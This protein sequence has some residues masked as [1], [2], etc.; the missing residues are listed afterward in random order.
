MMGTRLPILS[1]ITFKFPVV[2]VPFQ[3]RTP[4][5]VYVYHDVLIS[6]G[7]LVSLAP[8]CHM[9]HPLP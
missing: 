7:V 2:T 4:F 9:V 6:L 1:L 8:Q 3:V 5:Y